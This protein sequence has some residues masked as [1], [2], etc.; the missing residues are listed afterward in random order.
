MRKWRLES[1]VLCPANCGRYKSRTAK[2][3][4]YC[5]GK[6]TD[7]QKITIQELIQKA[8]DENRHRQCYFTEIRNLARSWN[9]DL[10]ELP[11][12]IC[13]YTLHSE[14]AHRKPIAAFNLESTIGEINERSNLAPLCRN[15]HWESEHGLVEIPPNPPSAKKPYTPSNSYKRQIPP[16]AKHALNLLMKTTALYDIAIQYNVKEKTVKD[17]CKKYKIAR[18]PAHRRKVI[19][20]S[21][22]KLIQLI[23]AKPIVDIARDFN[24]TDNAIRKWCVNYG[25]DIK[26]L[27][28]FVHKH[29]KE[30]KSPLR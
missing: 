12:L 11:C 28:P 20:P 14:I 16:P 21:M 13:G 4:R 29:N 18:K 25:L 15:C 22:S 2:H 27:S 19:R 8:Q 5:R 9:K 30:N 23:K 10:V 3:C 17:W 24:V 26:Q 7:V 6:G 1:K